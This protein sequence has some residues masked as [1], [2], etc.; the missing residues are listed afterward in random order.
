MQRVDH[1]DPTAA[2]AQAVDDL[3]NG[4]TGLVLVFAGSV[5][6][7]GFGLDPSP[8]TLARARRH[9]S[10]AVA[11]DL[12]L[13]PATR[14]VVRDFA[15]LV[16]GR[17]IAPSN[18]DLR[19][20]INPIGGY[21]ASG[22]GP[23][24]WQ[25]ACAESS[26][27]WS[28]NSPLPAF[29]GHSPLP[30]AASSTMRA[31]RKRRSLRSRGECGRLPARAGN[32]RHGADSGARC[33]LFPAVGRCR[34]VFDHGQI[35]RRAKTLGAHRASLPTLT[36]K[37]VMIA[38]ETAWRIMTRRDPTRTCYPPRSRSPPQA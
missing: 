29:M 27:R 21:A 3:Q 35:P 16:K 23:R 32:A 34:S 28:A 25:E 33:D 8:A 4:A 18:V 10:T 15:A 31:D 20:S 24:T 5:S 11:I 6:A 13:S 9:R 14:H 30:M 17:G 38:A 7:N 1:P 12:N 22:R 19:A 37:P 2:N 26:P 36:P